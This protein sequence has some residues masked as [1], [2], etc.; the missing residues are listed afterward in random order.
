VKKLYFTFVQS[1]KMPNQPFGGSDRKEPAD[2]WADTQIR[3]HVLYYFVFGSAVKWRNWLGRGSPASSTLWNEGCA[4]TST[5]AWGKCP[6][7]ILQTP[8]EN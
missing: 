6:K 4:A 8:N 5:V 3:A 2:L 1:T 7:E